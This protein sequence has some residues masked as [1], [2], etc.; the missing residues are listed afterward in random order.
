MI[1]PSVLAIG[2]GALRRPTAIAPYDNVPLATRNAQWSFNTRSAPAD[3]EERKRR[4]ENHD[5]C[6]AHA[7]GLI[8][9]LE[10]A[11]SNWSW[12]VVPCKVQ[13]GLKH[14]LVRKRDEAGGYVP[15]P[16]FLRLASNGQLA[17]VLLLALPALIAAMLLVTDYAILTVRHGQLQ[18]ACDLAAEAGA[19]ILLTDPQSARNTAMD[20]LRRNAPGASAITVTTNGDRIEVQAGENITAVGNALIGARA[21]ARALPTG[22]HKVNVIQ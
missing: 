6:L 2:S 7:W 9:A 10:E 19:A 21:V 1:E 11:G 8:R 15:K 20:Y 22:L 3:T 4:M 16:T 14:R 17:F 12:A 18:A 5:A 13:R